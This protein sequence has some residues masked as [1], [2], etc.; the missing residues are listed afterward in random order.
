LLYAAAS[1]A[2]VASTSPPDS[3]AQPAQANTADAAQ[4]GGSA[5]GSADEKSGPGAASPAGTWRFEVKRENTN[6]G[7]EDEATK[8]NLRL[9][10]FFTG[11]VRQLRLDVPLPDQK[12]DF[13]GDPF[14]PGL[15]D[16]KVRVGFRALRSGSYSFPSFIE[17]TF[18]T[19][20]PES[21]G[22]RK[23]QLNLGF[24]IV[25]PV[26]LPVA[27]PSSHDT[28]FEFQI[29]QVN[30][31]G[32]DYDGKNVANTKFEITLYNVWRKEYTMKAKLKPSV[33]W[34]K[35]G[36]TGAV[37]EIE[38]GKYFGRDWRAWLMLGHRVWGPE[39]IAAT[40][41]T[42]VELGLARTF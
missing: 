21:L 22:G 39:G 33:D 16:M 9:E 28:T 1:L 4:P 36:D 5:P 15:G 7:T 32:G 20:D 31:F 38:G 11:P 40:Y 10:K 27:R 24:R 13:E 35:G 37:L 2:I 14:N 29:Q 34:V 18:P 25:R 19:A 30:S 42:K 23:Y 12:T 3:F 41:G 6:R 17:V 26:V 8:T